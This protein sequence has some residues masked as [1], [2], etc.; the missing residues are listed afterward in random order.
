MKKL[1]FLI[2]TFAIIHVCNAQLSSVYTSYLE[3]SWVYSE[4]TGATVLPT[5]GDPDDG[6]Y[7]SIPI[8]FNFEYGGNSYSSVTIGVNGAIKF[9]VGQISPN[10]DLSGTNAWNETDI[11]APLWDDLYYNS[12]DNSEIS[13]VTTGTAPN[14]TF[15]VQWKNMSWKNAGSTVNFQAELKENYDIA[16]Y[17]GSLNSTENQ[18]A[19]IGISNGISGTD[20]LSI[21]P[22]NP[23]G[24]SISNSVANNS[25]STN[26]FPGNGSGF[27]YQLGYNTSVSIDEQ[28]KEIVLD[29]YPNPSNGIFNLNIKLSE[30]NSL[31]LNIIDSEG[32][33]VY[34]KR[35]F[36][37]LN[38]I[39]EQIDLSNHAAGVYFIQMLTEGTIKTKK[40]IVH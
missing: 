33:I 4:I 1:F 17:Y 6:Q 40:I 21:T 37:N 15:I 28:N 29:T 5:P 26:Q 36:N 34:H 27:M 22:G 18:N 16:F 35:I 8:G 3:M 11:V 39:N 19:S 25:I 2:F 14:R 13:Y 24:G 20:F 38:E 30:T 7:S 12:S 31:K 23:L 9:T 10:N 32:Q